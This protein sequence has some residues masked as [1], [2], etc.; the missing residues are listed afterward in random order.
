MVNENDIIAQIDT[1]KVTIDVRYT[2]KEAGTVKEVLVKEG[3]TVQVGA[4]IAVVDQGAVS[5]APSAPKDEQPAPK[6]DVP[7]P[8]TP[9]SVSPPPSTPPAQVTL[10]ILVQVASRARTRG[11]FPLALSSLSLFPLL[12]P[13]FLPFL[14]PPLFAHVCI[15]THACSGPL[16]LTCTPTLMPASR[17]VWH[18]YLHLPS[19]IL[20]RTLP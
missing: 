16:L 10:G 14:S 5:A 19:T 17:L 15:S 2:E 18:F 13:Y 8:A 9:A 3:D 6:A 1:D 7:P 11:P 20:I 12:L 4:A